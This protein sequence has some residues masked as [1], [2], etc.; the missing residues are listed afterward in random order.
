M[1]KLHNTDFYSFK[2]HIE[3]LTIKDLLFL[4]NLQPDGWEDIIP[5]Y[6][7]YIQQPFCFPVAAFEDGEIV[8]VGSAISNGD[9]GWISHIIVHPEYRDQGIGYQIT[10]RVVETLHQQGC[11]TISLIATELGQIVYRKLGFEK[12]GEYVFLKGDAPEFSSEVHPQIRALQ[13]NDWVELF[14]LDKMVSGENRKNMIQ[15]GGE[16]AFA[17]WDDG[18]MTG[19]YLPGLGEGLINALTEEAGIALLELKHSRLTRQLASMPTDNLAAIEYLENKDFDI[20]KKAIRM[21]LGKALNWQGDKI[22][23]RAGGFFG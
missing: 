12:D 2:M 15:T 10:T 18:E 9:T 11:E 4:S 22:Y 19:Y 16:E 23:S 21:R 14:K 6:R 13:T 8:G 1:D 5:Y 20:F 7:M 3:T 17:Y